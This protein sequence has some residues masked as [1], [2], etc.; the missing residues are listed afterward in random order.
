[1]GFPVDIAI[2]SDPATATHIPVCAGWGTVLSGARHVLLTPP[3]NLK[4]GK[5]GLEGFT[6]GAS[7]ITNITIPSS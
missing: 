4:V 2:I 5:L 3:V 7:I 6:V 1:M